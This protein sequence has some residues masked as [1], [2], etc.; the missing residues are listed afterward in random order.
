[1]EQLIAALKAA[2][3]AVPKGK[4]GHEKDA[5]RVVRLLLQDALTHAEHVRDHPPG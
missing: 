2:Q 4:A 3:K 5:L 1:M